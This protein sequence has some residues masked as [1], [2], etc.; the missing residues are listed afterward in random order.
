MQRETF[1]RYNLL[2]VTVGLVSGGAKVVS[3][4]KGG[5]SKAQAVT[6]IRPSKPRCAECNPVGV[7]LE[8]IPSIPRRN[9]M[10][11]IYRPPRKRCRR[12]D[13]HLRG[14]DVEW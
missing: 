12:R 5:R 14:G 3:R 8:R 11:V 2:G 13:H 9:E 4:G 7:T 10:L 1:G 6:Q